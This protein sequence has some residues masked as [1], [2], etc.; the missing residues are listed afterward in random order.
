VL[1]VGGIISMIIGALL[2]VDAPI[3]EMRVHLIT[4]LSVS[5]PI[6]LITVFLISIGLRARRRKADTGVQ[7][8]MGITAIARTPLTPEGKVFVHGELWNAIASVDVA[9][10]QEVLVR[11]VDGLTLRVDPIKPSQ[12]TRA[13]SA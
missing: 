7:G 3:P 6:G 12:K 8:L 11:Q 4:A 1:T 9:A 5:I 10:G 2:L 13:D